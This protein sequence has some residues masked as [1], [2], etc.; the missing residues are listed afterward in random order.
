[1]AASS[2]P[3]LTVLEEFLLLAL[4]D[5]TGTFYPLPRADFDH[6]TAGA[7]IMDLARASRLDADLHNI[8]V[9]AN[10]PLDDNVL[11]PIL[12]LMAVAPVMTPRPTSLWLS[13]LAEQ[14]EGLRARALDRLGARRIIRQDGGRISWALGERR[15]PDNQEAETREVK[16]RILEVILSDDIPEPH[17]IML[18]ALADA[19]GLFQHML[20]GS[21]LLQAAPRI[22]KVAQL[23]L[24][25]Q[26]V[27]RL[28]RARSAEE[29]AAVSAVASGLG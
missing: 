18:T 12:Q 9:V 3:P 7:A 19:C 14:G 27:L 24:I 5:R 11:N 29:G 22:S 23:D 8:V 4:D 2:F 26:A 1:M 16:W 20:N 17:D 15:Y 28:M 10:A 25:G 6:A 21:E 13:L